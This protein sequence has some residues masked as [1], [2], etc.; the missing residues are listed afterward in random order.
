MDCTMEDKLLGPGKECGKDLKGRVWIESK[1]L[2]RIASP[3]ILARITSFGILVVTQSF[4]GHIGAT[5]LAAYAL[6]QIILVRFV[7]GILLGMGSAVE[8]LC[9]QAFGARHYHMMGIYL[10]RSWVVL[11][12]TSTI[13]LPFFI[14]SSSILRLIGQEEELLA[15]AENISLWFIPIMYTFTFSMTMQ[16]YLQ[17]QQKN[18][19][20]GWLC[21]ASFVGH[22]ILSWLFVYEL[23]WGIPGAMGAMVISMWSVVIGEFVYVFCGWCPGTWTGFSK[24]AFTDLWPVVK[25]SLSSGVMLCLELWYNA[26][27][28]IMAGFMKNA[29]IA[30][31]AFSICLNITAWEFMVSL[32]FLTAACV[33][34]SNELGR[35]DA[36]AA[37][38]AIK[39]NLSTSL[40]LG[41][42]FSVLFLIFGH[43]I[44]Y[45]FTSSTEVA[46]AVSSLTILLS[47][48]VLLNSIQPVLS[49]VAIGSGWQSV[50]AYVNLGCYYVVGVPVGVLLGYVAKLDVKERLFRFPMFL[51]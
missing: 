17:A 42:L 36:A 3:A 12:T 23:N 26:V 34:V 15:A 14:F 16:M 43:V 19:I 39:V 50:V 24:D 11:L 18:M 37:K 10:Q 31:S 9:G 51:S 44:S 48:S 5:E 41:V 6:V 21:S 28:V 45:A 4:I 13:L 49:G 32:G 22:L 40:S 38:F 20:I 1:Q 25:L 35:G 2:W 33:R 46:K 8:T 29:T 7:N 47:L 27:L 30:I